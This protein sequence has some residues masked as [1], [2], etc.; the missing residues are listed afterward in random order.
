MTNKKSKKKDKSH[1]KKRNKNWQIYKDYYLKKTKSKK[2]EDFLTND[3][4]DFEPKISKS[5]NKTTHSF[6]DIKVG[7]VEYSEGPV[8]CTYIHFDKGA[9][10]YQSTQGGCVA[11]VSMNSLFNDF[12]VAS[13]H[14]NSLTL[15]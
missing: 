5:K 15:F 12:N 8:G 1:I 4:Y 6:K 3:L 9:R 2:F 13:S 7:S 11:N 10:V 14:F